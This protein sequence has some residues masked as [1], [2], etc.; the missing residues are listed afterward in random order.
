MDSFRYVIFFEFG[1]EG[2]KNVAQDLLVRLSSLTATDSD[3]KL[4]LPSRYDSQ[5]G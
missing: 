4:G 2:F 5:D 3:G 1:S